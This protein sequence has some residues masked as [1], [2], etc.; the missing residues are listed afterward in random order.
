MTRQK[1]KIAQPKITLMNFSKKA[2]KI[3]QNSVFRRCPFL[4]VFGY[5]HLRVACHEG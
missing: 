2:L 1:N 4:A 5:K 3:A